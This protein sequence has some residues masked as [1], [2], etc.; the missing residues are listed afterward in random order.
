MNLS[1]EHFLTFYYKCW[2]KEQV[3]TVCLWCELLCQVLKCVFRYIESLMCALNRC[4][5]PQTQ[6]CV[7]P[8]WACQNIPCYSAL[9]TLEGPPGRPHL[10]P[11]HLV[12]ARKAIQLHNQLLILLKINTGSSGGQ[13]YRRAENRQVDGTH[14]SINTLH[15]NVS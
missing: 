3:Y 1:S 8:V 5:S 13:K 10:L 6:H 12:S 15:C 4:L 11:Q 2:V 7:A 14:V 9:P